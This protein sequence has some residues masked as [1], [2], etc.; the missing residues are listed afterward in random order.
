MYAGV[1]ALPHK[2]ALGVLKT[3]EAYFRAERRE[4]KTPARLVLIGI[5]SPKG[6]REEK[7]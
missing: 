5:D 7:R 2:N 1:S 6:Y 4:G 3:Y